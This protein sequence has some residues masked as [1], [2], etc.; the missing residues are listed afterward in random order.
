ME[1]HDRADQ[2]HLGMCALLPV[3]YM[4]AGWVS[5]LFA[6][7]PGYASPI[8]LPAGIAL[9]AVVLAGPVVLPSVFVGSL[10]LNALVGYPCRCHRQQ[11]QSR[12][13]PFYP[14]AENKCE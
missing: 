5:L 1:D 6:V 11:C 3:S 8:F 7:P 4:I 2:S 14:V 10:L 13:R 9:V 12:M